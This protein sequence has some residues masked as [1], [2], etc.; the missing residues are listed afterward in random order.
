VAERRQATLRAGR[1][2][3]ADAIGAIWHQ[4]WRDGHLGLVPEKLVAARTEQ[5]FRRRAAEWVSEMT[6]AEVD[7]AIAGFVLVLGDEVEQVYV[8]T[9]Y[10]GSGVADLLLHEAERLVAA[11]GHAKAWLAVVPGN[12][13]AR[14]FY[15]RNGWRDEGPFLYPAPTGDGPIPVPCRRYTKQL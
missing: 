3:D 1:P 8:A 9:G 7:G 5:S 11:N 4:G 15:E 10:R 6:L 13:R 2:Q 14:A 12:G